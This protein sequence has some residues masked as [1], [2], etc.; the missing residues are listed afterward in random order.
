MADKIRRVLVNISS[1]GWIEQARDI[2]D[3]ATST[4]TQRL[5]S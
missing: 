3:I 4:I 1:D 5:F 2:K